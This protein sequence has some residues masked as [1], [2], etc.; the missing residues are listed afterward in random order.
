MAVPINFQLSPDFHPQTLRSDNTALR[1]GI[2]SA[3]T[4]WGRVKNTLQE[5]E[6]AAKGD[7]PTVPQ[8]KMTP[9]DQARLDAWSVRTSSHR[10]E[11]ARKAQPM[12][13][14]AGTRLDRSLVSARAQRQ[15]LSDELERD[16]VP[17]PT[18]GAHHV[19]IRAT[20]REMKKP[21]DTL[22]TAIN[23]GDREVVAA[24]VSAPG[25]VT[26]LTN[27]QR[28]LVRQ[29]ALKRW[30]PEK[31]EALKNLDSDLDRAQRMRDA[32]LEDMTT[33]MSGLVDQES[34]I[35]ARG[36]GR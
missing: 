22:M 24:C 13:E 16:L 17:S 18:T 30:F 32:F 11:F 10:A 23:Q 2:E 33:T 19:E 20:V 27:E 12:I 14:G 25:L 15:K 4:A 31:V 36:L 21:L 1:D 8:R 26:G 7:R 5:L 3:Y 9:T 34:R 6:S 29:T 35:I 28:D